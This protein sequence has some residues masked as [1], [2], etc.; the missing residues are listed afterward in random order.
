MQ[1]L[2]QSLAGSEVAAEASGNWIPTAGQMVM[3]FILP[4]ALAF[5]A[6]PLE[7]F[8]HS[9][10]TVLGV[11]LV[12]LLRSFAFFLRFVGNIAK[13]ASEMLLKVY[14]LL[15]FAPLWI[16]H[17][18]AKGKPEKEKSEVLKKKNSSNNIE[19]GKVA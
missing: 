12:G 3:G 8:V 7:S 4:F 18:I 15:V 5:V 1:A 6:I 13:S 11:V 19:G 14:D 17:M 2:R 10:R 16:E 9:S